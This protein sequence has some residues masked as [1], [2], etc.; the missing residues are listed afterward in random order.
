MH[1]YGGR[2]DCPRMRAHLAVAAVAV[3]LALAG[4]SN[5][6]PNS[7]VDPEEAEST[8]YVNGGIVFAVLVAIVAAVLGIVLLVRRRRRERSVAA[9]GSQTRRGLP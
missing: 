2:G 7:P 6:Q 8:D 1:L 4:C 5:S 3:A 9:G